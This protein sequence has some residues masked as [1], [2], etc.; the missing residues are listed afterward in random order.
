[1]HRACLLVCPLVE[2]GEGFK[3]EG[4]GCLPRTVGKKLPTVGFRGP[5]AGK[6]GGPAA[7]RYVTGKG[8]DSMGEARSGIELRVCRSFPLV[9]RCLK[10]DI[11]TAQRG[12]GAWGAAAK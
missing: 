7:I 8:E 2:A 6:P 1:M 4:T 5:Q 11:G 12:M 10:N 3:S 9:S